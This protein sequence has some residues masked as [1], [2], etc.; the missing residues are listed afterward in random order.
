LRGS[1]TLVLLLWLSSLVIWFALTYFSF[2]L[3]IL[4]KSI[5]AA[6]IVIRGG[7]L[8]AIVG[9]QSLVLLGT[10]IADSTG[11]EYAEAIFVLTHALWGVGLILY[12]LFL[13]QFIHRVLYARVDPNDLTPLLWVVMGAAAISANA[14]SLLVETCVKHY[15]L[16]PLRPFIDGV[17][18]MVWAWGTWWIPL[19]A[20]FGLWKYVVHRVPLTY[21]L[22]LWGFVF[23]LAMYAV[24]TDRLSEEFA[25]LRALSHLMSW[26]ALV[27]WAATTAGF[28][29]ASANSFRDF[30]RSR[31]SAPTR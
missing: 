31:F 10:Q 13:G 6:D 3:L 12:G 17:S 22:T 25:S 21:T 2:G 26:V 9:T 7:W 28:I 1:T 24:T 19:L 5:P 23:P 8:L 16:C 18:L 20:M 29:A 14:G 27:A 4:F 30:A 11:G 15:P